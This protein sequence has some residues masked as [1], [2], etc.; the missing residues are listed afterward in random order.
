M[1]AYD[2]WMDDAFA[3]EEDMLLDTEREAVGQTM[4][5]REGFTVARAYDSTLVDD[6]GKEYIDFTAGWNVANVGWSRPE[7][8]AAITNQLKKFPYAP[9]WCA[10]DVTI[11]LAHRL[12]SLLPANLNTFF[13]ATGG[14][15]ANELAIKIARAHT[16]KKKIFSFYTEYHGQTMGSISLGTPSAAVP[17]DPTLPG[18]V[19]VFPPYFYRSHLAAGRSEAEFTQACLDQIRATIVMEGDAAAFLCETVLTCPGVI[20]PHQDF[21]KGLRKICDDFGM[22]LIIDEV[23]TGF[24]RTGTMF[25]FEQYG[26]TPDVIT[27]AKALSGGFGAIGAVAT[28]KEIARSMQGK[29]GTSTFGWHALSACAASV[30][31]DILKQEDLVA[32]ANEK[33]EYA[34]ARLRKELADCPIVGDIRGMGLEIGIELVKDK[35]TK[36]PNKDAVLRVISEG[37]KQGLHETWSGRTTTIM[38]MPPLSIPQEQLERG[39]S[40]LISIIKGTVAKPA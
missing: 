15:E 20:V 13:K 4:Q 30:V 14:T 27:M 40:L 26:I 34:L 12:R 29:G 9:M 16:G 5:D 28:S 24:G 31:L 32:A 21:F 17:F 3:V 23:G 39:L 6:K 37:L 35:T 1:M 22:L 19:K 7:V 25:G 38:V 10:T 33:G 18:F 11:G 8:T 36:E 2:V